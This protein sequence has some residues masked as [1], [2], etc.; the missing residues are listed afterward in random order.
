M[1][2]R[3]EVWVA[4][5]NPR[6]GTGPGKTRPVP[7]VQAQTV[8]DAGYPSALV[9]PLT[10]RFVD[11]AQPLRIRIPA[12][13]N[14]RRDSDVLIDQLR[15]I[16][17]RWLVEGP[18][19]RVGPQPMTRIGEAL[20]DVLELA[21]DCTSGV[22]RKLSEWLECCS[23]LRDRLQTR[24]AGRTDARSPELVNTAGCQEDCQPD[25]RAR[26]TP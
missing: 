20:L 3:G 26:L 24:V 18:L 19:S 13:G 15:A 7:I 17:N 23:G 2:E 1:P 9:T 14:L 6:S 21:E 8:L 25:S 12:T 11:G 22:E 16:D 5:L 10:T 4:D